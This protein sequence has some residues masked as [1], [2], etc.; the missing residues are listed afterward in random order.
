MAWAVGLIVGVTLFYIIPFSFL[1]MKGFTAGGMGLL[2]SMFIHHDNVGAFRPWFGKDRNGDGWVDGRYVDFVNPEFTD[3]SKTC[4]A[5]QRFV[6]SRRT[7]HRMA[8]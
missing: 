1:F 7:C 2:Q 6:R 3:T 4:S 5:T 8:G